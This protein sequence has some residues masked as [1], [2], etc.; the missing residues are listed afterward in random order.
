M[1]HTLEILSNLFLK[2]KFIFIKYKKELQ[3]Q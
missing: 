3:M 1:L 2:I